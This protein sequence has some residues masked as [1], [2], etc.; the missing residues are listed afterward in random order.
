MNIKL[1]KYLEIATNL[2][3]I[4]VAIMLGYLLIQKYFFCENK[5]PQP[6]VLQKD[7]HFC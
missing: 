5:Q 2:A 3:I 1:T 6:I 4:V 7:C